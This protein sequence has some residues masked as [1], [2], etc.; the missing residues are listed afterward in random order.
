[1]QALPALPAAKADKRQVSKSASASHVGSSI[2]C[3]TSPSLAA[4]YT[5]LDQVVDGFY[6]SKAPPCNPRK[7]QRT[8]LHPPSEA[9]L[10]KQRKLDN[11]SGGGY[12][13]TPAFWDSLSKI[14]LTKHALRELNRRN[15]SQHHPLSRRVRRPITRGLLAERRTAGQRATVA[16]LLRNASLSHLNDIKR[17]ARHGG[18]DLS[19]LVGV[20]VL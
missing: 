4:F 12:I 14:W 3:Y 16:D 15:T 1:M 7:R 19:D 2:A 18:P 6:M 11:H 10:K 9:P 20:C 5:L 17:F 13:N 8:E